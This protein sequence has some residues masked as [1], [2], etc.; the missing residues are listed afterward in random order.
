MAVLIVQRVGT[1]KAEEQ[2]YDKWSSRGLFQA[3]YSWVISAFLININQWFLV[4]FCWDSWMA[5]K[6]L[7][8][9]S[10]VFQAQKSAASLKSASLGFS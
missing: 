5:Y 10:A 7:L 1:F 2:G 4:E 8:S 3:W 9:V 6:Y